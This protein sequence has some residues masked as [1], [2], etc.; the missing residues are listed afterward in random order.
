MTAVNVETP[1]FMTEDLRIFEDGVG[2][3]LE[4]EVVPNN[5][6]YIAQHHVDRELWNKAGAAGLLVR[7]D[8]GRIWRRG[9]HLRA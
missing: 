7:L 5:E 9:R 4:R 8:A 3:F 6:R 2:K 1:L